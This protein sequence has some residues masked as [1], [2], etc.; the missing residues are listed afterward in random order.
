MSVDP[1]VEK[2]RLSVVVPTFGRPERIEALL[3]CLDRQT[4]APER[5]EV[6][7]VDDGTPEPIVVD[8]SAH[9]FRLEVLRQANA[10]PGAA[11]NRGVEHAR[12]ELVI[13]LNDDAVPAPDAAHREAG[14][15]DVAVLGTFTFTRESLVEP[16][17]QLC[18]DSTLLFDF[19]N[20]RDRKLHPWQFFWTC[21]ISLRKSTF[22]AVGGFDPGFREAIVEDVELG[23][24]LAK[25]GLQV[26]FR[27]D[28]RCDHAH[29]ITIEGYFKRAVRLGV[30]LAR[31]AKKHADP[32][33][34]WLPSGVQLNRS[35]L[36]SAQMT[37]EAY[38]DAAEKFV[39]TTRRWAESR[40]GQTVTKDERERIAKLTRQLSQIPFLRGVLLELTGTDPGLALRGTARAKELVSIVAC[41]YDALAK[42][43][44][45]VESLRRTL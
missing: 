16:F 40:R 20:L 14:T 30:N 39:E 26:L 24:R 9:R 28:A 7:L 8:A 18:A 33:I 21:N 23:Y 38:H 37:V 19:V 10:G 41:S 43:K 44:N 32:T 27:A 13:F 29:A 35:Y 42:T 17:T 36:L 2:P 34:L 4:L 5:F 1:S 31:M 25:R 15:K 45:C 22:D 6:I 12:A 3:A 11:R